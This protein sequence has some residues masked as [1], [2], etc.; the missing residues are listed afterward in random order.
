MEKVKKTFEEP[1]V[2]KVEFDFKNRI[3]FHSGC[4]AWISA[5]IPVCIEA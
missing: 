5:Q 3:A 4:D 2:Q 1:S